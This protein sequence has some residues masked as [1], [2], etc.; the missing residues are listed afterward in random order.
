MS[1]QKAELNWLK[2]HPITPVVTVW[3]GIAALVGI[4]AI[5]NFR[6]SVEL[7][8][9]LQDYTQLGG[10]AWVLIPLAFILVFALLVGLYAAISYRFIGYALEPEAIHYRKGI[11]FKSEREIKMSRIQAIDVVQPLLGRLFGLANVN[12]EATGGNES[13]IEIGMLRLPEA[14]ETRARILYLAAGFS[15]DEGESPSAPSQ[16]ENAETEDGSAPSADVTPPVLRATPVA[17]ETELY[18]VNLPSLFVSVALSGWFIT[19]V[20]VIIGVFSFA[21]YGFSSWGWRGFS[22]SLVAL[23][24]LFLGLIS[25]SWNSISRSINFVLAASPD[26]IR[27]RN[28]ITDLKAQTLPPGRV[29]GVKLSQSL[30]WRTR[31]YWRVEMEIA[32]YQGDTEQSNNVLIPVGSRQDAVSSSWLIVRD[33]GVENP[34]QLWEEAFDGSRDSYQSFVPNPLVSRWFDWFTYRRNA[35]AITPHALVF[36][37]G[38][39]TK[40]I[41]IVLHEH[42]QSVEISQGPWERRL[43]LANLHIHLVQGQILTV[44]P[45]IG[46]EH[47]RDLWAQ[48]AQYSQQRR[49]TEPSAKWMIRVQQVAAVSSSQDGSMSSGNTDFEM[50]DEADNPATSTDQEVVSL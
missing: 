22:G 33:L 46:A 8:H 41:N 18:R 13:K 26:G 16:A 32:S 4:I 42:I 2:V 35:V 30:L 25:G 3:K 24:P 43:G 48:V 20:I 14:E 19:T 47:C 36:R 34:D 40:S 11:F 5:Q 50:P 9:Y 10:L 44:M 15:E 38:W 23:A 12:V 31:D 21:I 45:N 27:I 28:G 37:R 1:D 49:E 7:I 39:L 6:E 17:P 29:H